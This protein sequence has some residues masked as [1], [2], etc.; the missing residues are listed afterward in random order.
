MTRSFKPLD[1]IT[2]GYLSVS[3]IFVFIGWNRLDN[4]FDIFFANL[5]ITVLTLLICKYAGKYKLVELLHDWYPLLFCGFFFEAATQM[6]QILWN[7]YWDPFI[8]R[9]EQAI[10]GYQPA[11]VWGTRYSN[12]FLQE[13]FHFWYL[14]FYLMIIGVGIIYYINNKNHFHRYYFAVIFVFYMS[15]VIYYFIPVVG[16]RFWPETLALTK[17]YRFGIFTRI[18]AFV[19]NRTGHWGGA[20]PSSHVA[21]AVAVTAAS[22]QINK[23]LGWIMVVTTVLLSLSTVYCHYHYFIDTPA[24]IIWGLVLFFLSE[25]I[26]KKMVGYV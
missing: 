23:I 3:T 5:T 15:Y 12:Y 10:F 16:G 1:I 6:N 7:G 19:Y 22:F 2:L 26:Y 17:E 14:S 9:I 13:F 11:F 21:V 24:G 18:M 25:K 8:H 20:I 4:S